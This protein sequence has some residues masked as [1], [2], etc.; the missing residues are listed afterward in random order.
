[1]NEID[2]Q[3]TKRSNNIIIFFAVLFGLCLLIILA[4][5]FYRHDKL[6]RLRDGLISTAITAAT[7][8]GSNNGLSPAVTTPTPSLKI[9]ILMYHY[10]RD[11]T[12]PNDPGGISLSVSTEKFASQLNYLKSRGYHT[13]TFTDVKKNQIPS[14]PII[15]TF[16]DGYVDFY[17]NAFPEL[18]SHNMVAVTFIITD[19]NGGD[20][21]MNDTELREIDKYG[22][23][24]GSHTV[25]HPNLTTASPFHAT[26]Q[27]V[28]SKLVLENKIGHPIISFC[29]PSGKYNP[30]IVQIV[31]GAGYE[32]ATTT[33][34]G[35]A[36]FRSHFTLSRLRMKPSLEISSILR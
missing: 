24:I 8:H 25:S 4:F 31:E 11:Y 5:A 27:I 9:P 13:I 26:R 21:Y 12:D 19:F 3:K 35:L 20:K 6:A 15:L 1:M 29:Y 32:Y 18:K 30:A 2:P 34:E 10:I 14:K 7:S 17:Q 22:I 33:N 16:D 28:D 36:D 23:E